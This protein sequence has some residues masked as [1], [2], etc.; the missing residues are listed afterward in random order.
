MP[1]ARILDHQDW[2]AIPGWIEEKTLTS[3]IPTELNQF[4]PLIFDCRLR[5]YVQE[6]RG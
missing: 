3:P 4:G 5:V 6:F 2:R 1:V